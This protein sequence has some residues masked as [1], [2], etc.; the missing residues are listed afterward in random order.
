[1]PDETNRITKNKTVQLPGGSTVLVPVITQITFNDPVDRGQD[2]QYTVDNSGKSDRHVHV[3]WV[4]VD[5]STDASEN[6]D[7]SQPTPDDAIAVERI[8]L[9]KVLDSVDRGQ[10]TDPAPDNKTY[11]PDGP[12]YFTT[13]K[14]THVVRYLNTPDDGNWIESELIDQ[15]NMLD[16]V[17]RA[18]ETDF[19][20]NN[21]PGTDDGQGNLIVQA[22]PN[23]PD[24]TDSGDNVDPPWRIDPFQNLVKIGAGY[25]L[26]VQF[27]WTGPDV[28]ITPSVGRG[29]NTLLNTIITIAANT[30]VQNFVFDVL[31]MPPP[32]QVAETVVFSITG[33]SD[34]TGW[35]YDD[36]FSGPAGTAAGL[37]F[38]P[39]DNPGNDPP[40]F[41]PWVLV[42]TTLYSKS[43][44]H[45]DSTD[46]LN[47]VK[48]NDP[49]NVQPPVATVSPEPAIYQPS[50]V[51]VPSED[52]A[53][54]P[55][56]PAG[57][58]PVSGG[59]FKTV[60]TFR[61]GAMGLSLKNVARNATAKA[62]PVVWISQPAVT[63]LSNVFPPFPVVVS[64]P[65]GGTGEYVVPNPPPPWTFGLYRI[66][67]QYATGNSFLGA[68]NFGSPP[69]DSNEYTGTYPPQNIV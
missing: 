49:S 54:Y 65:P 61:A 11:N 53:W 21:P 35:N 12:P 15:I 4:G 40:P 14:K 32:D 25:L 5:G 3:A 10:E 57:Y 17:E 18:Q 37:P 56:H 31:T 41:T 63:T 26:Y 44:Y 7:T 33:Q 13:H 55:V 52:G 8:D 67:G 48:A 34:Y 9:W 6:P 59:T 27:E 23:A 47:P 29:L 39:E 58:N 69:T 45:F 24:I 43:S 68:Y 38:F 62:K 42:S 36:T 66:G 64:G 51:T 22:D 1:M 2:T 28:T 50:F 60:G 20:L 19:T 30:F 46:H 16:P